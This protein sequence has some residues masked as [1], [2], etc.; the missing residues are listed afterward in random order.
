MVL[1][2]CVAV[3]SQTAVPMPRTAEEIADLAA[4]QSRVYLDTFR[5]LLSEEKKTFDIFDKKG[6]VKKRRTVES[7]FIVYQFSKDEAQIAEYRNVTSVDGKKI[8]NTDGRAQNFFEKV[9]ESES[10]QKERERIQNESTRYDEELQING[11]TLFQAIALSEPLRKSFQFR[12]AGKEMIDGVETFVI[13]YAQTAA[14]RFVTVNSDKKASDSISHNYDIDIDGEEIGLN[15]RIRG[16]MWIDTATFNLRREI[17]ERTIQPAEFD[18]PLVVAE[19]IF[20]Y[21]GSEFGILT[22]KKI[23]HMQY[24]CKIKDR[25]ALKE[26]RATFEY[27]VF[28][29]PDVEVKS[30]DVKEQK[31]PD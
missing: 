14:N 5:N 13:A 18:K 22:P 21:N 29:K 11:L 1:I 8:N 15:P 25:I 30:A 17:R 31:Q 20:E 27:A 2:S 24:R 23:M 7:T 3:R 10:S 19:N 26:I 12:L 4:G 28:T 16:K 6:E 9:V